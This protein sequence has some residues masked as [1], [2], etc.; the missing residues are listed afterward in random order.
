MF[1]MASAN[2]RIVEFRRRV[3]APKSKYHR[4]DWYKGSRFTPNEDTL[5]SE[6]DEVIH[7]SLRSRMAPGVSNSQ[8]ILNL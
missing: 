5:I 2:D 7:K 4:S 1:P 3:N 6:T 8:R